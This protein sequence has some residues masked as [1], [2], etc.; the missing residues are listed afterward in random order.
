MATTFCAG[1]SWYSA[2]DLNALAMSSSLVMSY[3][4]NVL[5]VVCPE[6]FIATVC[7][8]PERIRLRM[9]LRRVS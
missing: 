2:T 3:L 5:V 9:P 8:T 7:E 6:I 1:F 4:R